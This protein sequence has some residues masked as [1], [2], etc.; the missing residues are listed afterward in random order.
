MALSS[1]YT[2][3]QN[4]PITPTSVA[5]VFGRQD[6]TSSRKIY[7]Y[8]GCRD[9]PTGPCQLLSSSSKACKKEFTTVSLPVYLEQYCMCTND[10]YVRSSELVNPFPLHNMLMQVLVILTRC[11]DRKTRCWVDCY[12]YDAT[13]LDTESMSR[14]SRLVELRCESYSIEI[15]EGSAF[16]NSLSLQSISRQNRPTTTRSTTA[17]SGINAD[18]TLGVATPAATASSAPP[19]RTN[20][21]D[22]P[23]A[24]GQ[25]KESNGAPA[26]VGAKYNSLVSVT[27][28]LVILTFLT[29]L[30][31]S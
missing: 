5:L 19:E 26:T 9:D 8:P 25:A 7:S 15:E 30:Q 29:L 27:V 17:I 24:T 21:V 10:Y 1:V 18:P 3:G 16:Y 28:V 14:E 2:S 13:S 20:W 6:I 11:Y 31:P 23:T 12:R 22:R 4:I